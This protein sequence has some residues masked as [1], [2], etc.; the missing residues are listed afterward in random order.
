M[1][2]PPAI[3]LS[4]EWCCF[5]TNAFS[6]STILFSSFFGSIAAV[7]SEEEPISFVEYFFSSLPGARD[8]LK[9]GAPA[10]L[11]NLEWCLPS[12]LI[13][14][15][16]AVPCSWAW[17]GLGATLGFWDFSWAMARTTQVSAKINHRRRNRAIMGNRVWQMLVFSEAMEVNWL[18]L[19]VWLYRCWHYEIMRPCGWW[20]FPLPWISGII[21]SVFWMV[22]LDCL[23]SGEN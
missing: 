2:P 9:A 12:F 16:L 13:T 8:G 5:F 4:V 22:L 14:G 15:V 11:T 20:K 6:P 3:D 17:E 10:D 1:T 18:L 21:Y 23:Q 7:W 19:W